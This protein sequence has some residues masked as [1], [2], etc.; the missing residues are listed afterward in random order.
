HGLL[1]HFD[2]SKVGLSKVVKAI[3]MATGV[4]DPSRQVLDSRQAV[5]R[6]VPASLAPGFPCLCFCGFR[7]CTRL[8]GP[9]P[10]LSSFVLQ[11]AHL[12]LPSLHSHG[13]EVSQKMVTKTESL[14]A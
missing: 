11:P 13:T 2:M 10:H 4:P 14:T 3:R 12:L 6:F 7:G 8:L 5:Q 9:L 1:D